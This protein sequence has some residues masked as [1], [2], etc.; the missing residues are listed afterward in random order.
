MFFT[1][2]SSLCSLGWKSAER[3]KD[4][5]ERVGRRGI[6]GAL[7]RIKVQCPFPNDSVHVKKRSPTPVKNEQAQRCWQGL[8]FILVTFI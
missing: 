2:V 3:M 1:N 6:E 8:C 7:G 5:P 4:G